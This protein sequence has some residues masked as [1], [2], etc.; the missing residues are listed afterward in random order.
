MAKT[1]AER[2]QLYRS[3]LLRNKSKVEQ[4]KAKARQRNNTRRKNLDAKSLEN[5]RLRQKNASKR[6]RDKFWK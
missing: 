2:Q 5:L 3:N 1:N 4:V 6:Y